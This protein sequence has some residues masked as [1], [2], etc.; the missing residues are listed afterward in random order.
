MKK[1]TIDPIT[2][3]EGHGKIDI[4]LDDAGNVADAYLQIP[5][6]RGFEK[7]CQGRPVEEMPRI[8]SRICG[9][10]PEA[11][12]LASAKAGDAVYGMELPRTA[13]MLRELLY[14]IFFVTDHATH[15][16]ALGG[17]DFI[18]GPDA[19]KAQRNILGVIHKVGIEIGSKVIN[20]RGLCH[21]LIKKMAGKAVHPVGA[22]PGGM[23]KGL[24]AADRLEILEAG[25]QAVEFGQFTIQIFNDI[26]LK[27]QEYV[28][29]ILSDMFSHRTYNMG[30]VD[31]N[32]LSNFYEGKIRVTGPD[33]KEFV[34]FAAADY[35]DHIE[36]RVEPWS[37]LKFPYL[38][39]I[40]WKGFVDG[41]ES[42]IYK[43]TPLS[44]CNAADGLATPLAHAEYEKMY[45]TLGGKPVHATLA[46]HWARV[47]EMLYA[48]ERWVELAED[49]EIAGPEYRI[50][51]TQIPTEGVGVVEA[52]RGTLYHHYKTDERGM[53]TEANLIVGTTN[54]NAAINMSVKKAAM[55]LIKNG[56]VD[57]AL[58]NQVEMGFRAYDPCF[59]CATH[60]LP[61]QMPMILKIYD[62]H[63]ELV[64]TLRRD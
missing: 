53:I 4:F 32:N 25:R 28:D 46:T 22:L 20:M 10:C 61:G 36:E 45:D 1:I 3:L 23:S 42:G 54:N 39:N 33:G 11:H 24:T 48:A 50:Q 57:D 51:P 41:P 21:E 34:K 9:V 44:R 14:M 43:A 62:H 6:L 35:L 31:E 52:P 15:F 17:P 55:G 58:L 16:Y 30:L 60:T 5:E 63:R 2:R 7:F 19:P 64:E 13:K 40:G 26:V 12:L 38:K 29:L 18:V 47:I 56:K 49:P 59:G 8:T 37:Y 27:N